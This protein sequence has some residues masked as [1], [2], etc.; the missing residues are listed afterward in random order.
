MPN[1]G[2]DKYLLPASSSPVLGCLATMEPRKGRRVLLFP[3]ALQG[4]INPMLQLSQ[5]LHSH[6][7]SITIIHTDFNSPNPS[8][9]PH[10][11]FRS[12]PD[13]INPSETDMEDVIALLS[14]LNS[15]CQEPLEKCL[16]QMLLSDAENEPIVCFISDAI[17]H[18]TQGV[19]ERKKIPRFVLRTGGACSL[20]VFAAFPFLRQKGYLPIQGHNSF[21]YILFIRCIY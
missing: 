15:N 12:I 6:G 5:I 4:H 1:R 21:P 18:F 13:G 9:Y 7:F 14:L 17:F 20:Q 10:F 8:N 11:T 3:L 19:A 2:I 16:E